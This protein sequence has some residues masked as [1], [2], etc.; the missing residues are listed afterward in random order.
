MHLQGKFMS[1]ARR[2][3][4]SVQ[5]AP[6]QNDQLKQLAQD[7][8]IPI[9]TLISQIVMD[10]LKHLD[11]VAPTLAAEPLVSSNQLSEYFEDFEQRFLERT[12][13]MEQRLT[14]KMES[15]AK[16]VE[17]NTAIGPKLQL[18]LSSHYRMSEET[19][20][21]LEY[22]LDIA[23]YLAMNESYKPMNDA[24]IA[25]Q[26]QYKDKAMLEEANGESL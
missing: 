18:T 8:G 22:L 17:A 12:G 11:E 26:K 21:L 13:A 14:T 19:Q 25:L 4:H 7:K 5:F 2:E 6:P 20:S 16:S 1:N 24:Q 9:A 3:R 15:V 23:E 10:Y